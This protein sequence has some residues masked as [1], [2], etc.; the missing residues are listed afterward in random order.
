MD[1]C[2]RGGESRRLAHLLRIFLKNGQA[3]KWTWSRGLLWP[4]ENA[5]HFLK[6]IHLL[7]VLLYMY[8]PA[9]RKSGENKLSVQIHLY[10]AGIWWFHPTQLGRFGSLLTG[11]VPIGRPTLTEMTPCLESPVWSAP[12]CEQGGPGSSRLAM[13]CSKCGCSSTAVDTM[14]AIALHTVPWGLSLGT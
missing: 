9:L 3:W 5:S 11:S 12:V 1:E 10:M 2:V 13:S 8:A 6:Q 14:G 7:M 4:N